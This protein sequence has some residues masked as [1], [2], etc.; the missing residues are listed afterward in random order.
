LSLRTAARLTPGT[1]PAA[2]SAG[3]S[4]CSGD[5]HV[6]PVCLGARPAP[7]GSALARLAPAGVAAPPSY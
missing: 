3:E 7:P 1:V 5:A 6:V 2:T 4:T